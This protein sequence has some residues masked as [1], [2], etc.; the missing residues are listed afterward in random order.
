MRYRIF[1]ADGSTAEGDGPLPADVEARGV[2]VV[3]QDD[4]E[5]E[6]GCESI[7]GC[8]YF[9]FR[10]GRWWGVDVNGLFDWLLDTGL[11]MQGRLITTKEYHAIVNKALSDKQTWLQRERRPE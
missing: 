3:L 5:S 10:D 6:V 8:D 2:Q 9:I 1:Y 7:T 11:F 4:P